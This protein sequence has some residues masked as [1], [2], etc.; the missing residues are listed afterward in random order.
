MNSP[1]CGRQRSPLPHR[2]A[3][4][5]GLAACLAHAFLN[6]DSSIDLP[7][8]NWKAHCQLFCWVWF[9]ARVRALVYFCFHIY[10]GTPAPEED[11][12][13]FLQKYWWMVLIG[14]MLVSV[15]FIIFKTEISKTFFK[16]YEIHHEC[17]IFCQSLTAEEPAGE[18][19][20]AGG[21]G[22]GAKK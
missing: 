5:Q 10:Q 21:G 7:F 16:V 17:L 15:T 14:V 3:L 19:A 20:A 13:S 9:L 2:A 11:E 8:L 18:G 4:S 22:G 1:P 6:R 12:R